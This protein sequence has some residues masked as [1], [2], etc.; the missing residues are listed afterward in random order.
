MD[1][2]K[3]C[4]ISSNCLLVDLATSPRILIKWRHKT[5][6]CIT[7]TPIVQCLHF[8]IFLIFRRPTQT[9]CFSVTNNTVVV[10]PPENISRITSCS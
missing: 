2:G 8:E 10:S 4:D 3:Q 7:F 5:G 6:E 1:V 9:E